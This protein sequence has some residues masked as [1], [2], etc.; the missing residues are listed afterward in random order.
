MLF[1]VY[2][3]LQWY[4]FSTPFCFEKFQRGS[5]TWVG[6]S[7]IVLGRDV[8]DIR[9]GIFGNNKCMKKCLTPTSLSLKKEDTF[10]LSDWQKN[11][12]L[13]IFRTVLF[14]PKLLV[15]IYILQL[16]WAA[17]SQYLLKLNMQISFDPFIPLLGI[18]PAKIFV[19]VHK[20]ECM[21]DAQWTG[22]PNG[23]PSKWEL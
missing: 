20:H 6:F 16:V 14:T 19:H 17:M 12:K 7:R 11:C 23:C 10:C 8:V 13:I 1:I 15:G 18:S 5:K 22:K 3:S 2:Q 4:T 21:K 9:S